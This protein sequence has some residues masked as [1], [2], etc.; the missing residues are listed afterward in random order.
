M[1]SET[2]YWKKW[3]DDQARQAQSDY[4]LNRGT[5]LRFDELERRSLAQ[6]MEAVAPKS[7]DRVLDAGCGSGRN[8]SL[9]SPLVKEIA[10][11]DFSE[12]MLERARARVIEEKLGN[13]SLAQ[14]SVT[15]LEFP[16]N[17]FDKVICASVL[18]YLDNKD[19]AEAIAEMIRVAKPGGT[20]VLHV[21]N[22]T[23]LYG[24]SIKLARKISSMLGRK[25]KPEIYRSRAW[26]ER[27]LA[28]AGGGVVD[29]DGFGF[30]TFV[31][32]PNL[33]VRWLLWLELNLLT[34]KFLKR[35]AVNYKI[36]IRANKAAA[37]FR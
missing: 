6:F 27:T 9:L 4:S 31:P 2:Q 12:Q 11:V 32:L 28:A 3:F 19:C 1:S 24:V 5:S 18:Q 26:H 10:G 22:G 8:I 16:D 35:F 36:T 14:G 25:V 20:L 15:K 33:F 17:S 29:Y 34:F 37:S 21:K 23:S 30:L 13:V 7:S